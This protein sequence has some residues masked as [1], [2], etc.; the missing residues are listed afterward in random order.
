VINLVTIWSIIIGILFVL[1]FVG[2]IYPIIPSVLLIWAGYLIYHFL[3]DSTE[4]GF[5]FYSIVLGLTVILFF[6]DLIFTNFFLDKTN[7]SKNGKVVGAIA[8]IVGSFIF[9]PFGLIVVPFIAVLIVEL[10]QKKTLKE[11]SY[12]SIGTILGFLSSTFAKF[13][14]QLVMV[15]LFIIW[16]L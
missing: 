5:G 7:T 14:I 13:A 4:L 11:A 12:S 8:L 6:A 9:P 10:I 2:L 3:I 16:I 15:I 1:S